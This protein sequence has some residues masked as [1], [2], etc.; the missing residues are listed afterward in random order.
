MKSR[1]MKLAPRMEFRC[2]AHR[3]WIPSDRQLR[4][5][6][7][8]ALAQAPHGALAR[9]LRPVVSIH[10][11]GAR[12]GRTLNARY[13]GKDQPTNVL[14]FPGPGALP[15]GEQLLGDIVICAP[16]MAREA[17][18]QEKPAAAHWAHIVVH[19]VLHLLGLD[20]VRARD[21]QA[22]EA[23]EVRVL[24]ELRIADPYGVA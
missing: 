23:L 17:R 16:V 20:H 12:A 4:T 9:K 7:R 6:V 10:I 24:K 5:W 8:A 2:A 22:M 18:E 11:V 19:G 1:S 13:R 3:P 14:S 21:A 15:S